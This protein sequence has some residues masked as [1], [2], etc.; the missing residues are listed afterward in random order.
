MTYDHVTIYW[1]PSN[2]AITQCGRTAHAIKAGRTSRVQQLESLVVCTPNVSNMCLVGILVLVLSDRI[3]YFFLAPSSGPSEFLVPRLSC[4]PLL[5]P[6]LVSSRF[7]FFPITASVSVASYLSGPLFT[8]CLQTSQR[9]YTLAQAIQHARE[10][11]DHRLA[12]TTQ[13][14]PHTHETH[15][16]P[17]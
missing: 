15:G 5:F 3:W 16:G 1:L 9:Y 7:P 12:D 2:G 4:V 11:P 8:L 17:E 14:S 10:G 6:P 13:L